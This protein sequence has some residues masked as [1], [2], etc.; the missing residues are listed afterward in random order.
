MRDISLGSVAV[1]SIVVVVLLALALTAGVSFVLIKIGFYKL[2]YRPIV[3]LATFCILV[4]LIVMVV[5]V[6]SPS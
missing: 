5:T 1:S 2:V 4:G 6:V 3:E